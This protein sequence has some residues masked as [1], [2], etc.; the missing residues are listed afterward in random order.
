VKKMHIKKLIAVAFVGSMLV[1]GLGAC[2]GDDDDSGDDATSI[3]QSDDAG[4]DD[5][6]DD[7]ADDGGDTAADE[8]RAQFIEGLTEAGA[9]DEQA[10][11]M[12]DYF[13]E[14]SEGGFA[15]DTASDSDAQVIEDAKAACG[16]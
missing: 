1:G 12:A 16:L 9:T 8:H 5:M 3:D 14:N 13:D 15:S 7:A 11:C 10:E 2:G 6:G 4:D